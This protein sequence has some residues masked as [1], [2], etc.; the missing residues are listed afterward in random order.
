MR[1]NS[2]YALTLKKV[3]IIIIVLNIITLLVCMHYSIYSALI[4]YLV[5]IDWSATMLILC[6]GHQIINK[7]FLI[8]ICVTMAIAVIGCL[9]NSGGIG[10]IVILWNFLIMIYL[11]VHIKL[12]LYTIQI[13]SLSYIL[14]SIYWL[15]IGEAG[16]YNTNTIGVIAL[17]GV[18]FGIILSTTIRIRAIAYSI[19]ALSFVISY[20]IEKNISHSRTCFIC[21]VAM[22]VFV[23][24]IPRKIMSLKFVYWTMVSILTVGS[25]AWTQLYVYMYKTNI[26]L[27][28]KFS[29]KRFFTGREQI[30]IEMWNALD[31]HWLTG[32]G[33]G[34]QMA[35]FMDGGFNVHNSMFNFLVVYGII[36]FL[37]ILS[38]L[39]YKFKDIYIKIRFN[40]ETLSYIGMCAI[41]TL[42]IHALAEVSFISSV[43]YAPILT[44][45][46]IVN[47]CTIQK[48]I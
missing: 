25:L 20:M 12:Q 26:I 30:W 8:F 5:V 18:C 1:M 40:G 21:G 36:V 3:D 2:E 9:F 17:L 46:C 34:Y 27:D 24:A 7:H 4:G 47:S 23:Y 10:S 14:L 33:S 42:F 28:L 44:L 39:L 29:A 19:V 38:A 22:I 11:S 45:L 15:L 48:N 37:L 16:E 31:A 35:S 43:F 32:V 41:F 6:S 13:I